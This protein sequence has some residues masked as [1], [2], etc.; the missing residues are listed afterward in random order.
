MTREAIIEQTINTINKLPDNKLRELS[1]Y[2]SFLL[3]QYEESE[4]TRGIQKMAAE[5]KSF[6]FLDKEEDLYTVEDLKEVYHG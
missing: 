4:I 6:E 3:K 2:I 1:N 5:S